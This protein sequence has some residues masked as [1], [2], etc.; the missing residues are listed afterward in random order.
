MYIFNYYIKGYV[1]SSELRYQINWHF[2]RIIQIICMSV[3]SFFLFFI[4][5]LMPLVWIFGAPFCLER[6]H[7][8]QWPRAPQTTAFH[9]LLQNTVTIS[10]FPLVAWWPVLNHELLEAASRG[11]TAN[12]NVCDCVERMWSVHPSQFSEGE[13]SLLLQHWFLVKLRTRAPVK[14]S[15]GM[16][17]M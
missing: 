5:L 16:E 3:I 14:L 4:F 17:N 2:K 6:E 11:G 15:S 8:C 1:I 7:Q 12:K 10:Q 9:G 13:H